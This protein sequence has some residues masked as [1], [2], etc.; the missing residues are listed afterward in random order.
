MAKD[1]IAKADTAK[2]KIANAEKAKE[3][4]AKAKTAK[5]NMAGWSIGWLMI[6]QKAKATR[7]KIVNH[8]LAQKA[9][10]T[11]AKM[12]KARRQRTKLRLG[13]RRRQGP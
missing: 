10:E 2:D 11:M 5:E 1:K 13:K 6:A 4:F 9:K 3:K 8:H 12:A 7:E